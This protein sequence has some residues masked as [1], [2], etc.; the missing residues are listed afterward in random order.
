KRFKNGQTILGSYTWAKLISDTD[1]LT[2]W[3]EPSG[4]LTVQNNN[5]LRLKRSL[6][7]YDVAHRLVVSYVVDA[8]FGKG[9]HFLSGLNPVANKFVSGW[10]FIGAST[11]ASGNPLPLTTAVNL[12]NSFGGGSRPNSTGQSAKLDGSAQSR[13]SG[14][15]NTAAFTAP[16]AFTF[17]NV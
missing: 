4:G 1:T 17:G 5:N 3:L 8:P 7:N 2:A 10:N 9:K 12:T 6:A 13:L 11:F 15:F 14:W 16:A